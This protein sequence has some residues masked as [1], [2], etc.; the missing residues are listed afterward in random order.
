MVDSIIGGFGD[1]AE[2]YKNTENECSLA[3]DPEF[4]II[5]CLYDLYIPI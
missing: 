2:Y 5:K 1:W 3:C 4:L